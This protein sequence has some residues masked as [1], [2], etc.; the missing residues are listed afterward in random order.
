A[1]KGFAVVAEEI[2]KLSISSK[3]SIEKIDEVLGNIYQTVMQMQ[4]NINEEK[5]LFRV[6]AETLRELSESLNS[7]NSIAT[8]LE[9]IS[10]I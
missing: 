1:G 9:E 10:R 5:D 8:K 3:E 2:R 4:V 6:Q 7:I